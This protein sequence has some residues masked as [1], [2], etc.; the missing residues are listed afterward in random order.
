MEEKK[1]EAAFPENLMGVNKLHNI[2]EKSIT[3]STI[4]DMDSKL[5]HLPTLNSILRGN[6]EPLPPSKKKKYK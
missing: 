5:D 2:S 1:P 4:S 6:S 3:E